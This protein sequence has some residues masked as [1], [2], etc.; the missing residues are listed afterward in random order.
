MVDDIMYLLSIE[1]MEDRHDDGAIGEGGEIGNSPMGGVTSTNGDAVTFLNSRSLHHDMQFLYL[2][3][4]V[5]ILQRRTFIVCQRVEQPVLLNRLNDIGVETWYVVHC[6]IFKILCKGN[7]FPA[8]SQKF[9][10]V[11]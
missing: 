6:T 7:I 2:A 8:H 1:L 4:Y 3:G 11:F 5:V 9:C 10:A